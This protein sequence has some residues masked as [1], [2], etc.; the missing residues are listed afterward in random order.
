MSLPAEHRFIL[1]KL[2]R[3]LPPYLTY[4]TLEHTQDVLSCA[5]RIGLAENI[6]DHDMRL[7]LT[8]AA[9]HDSGYIFQSK[10]HEE[11][12]CEIARQ[13][14]AGFGYSGQEIETI[15]GMIRA[16]EVPQQ[17]ETF[18]EKIICDADL[19]YLG[20]DDFYALGLRLF[21]EMKHFGIVTDAAS[22]DNLQVRFLESHH[23]F[24]DISRQTRQPKK[25]QHLKELLAKIQ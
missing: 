13:D 14:L 10:G 24:T 12:S 7:L 11:K 8:A 18:L 2:Q 25:D 23:Y 6:S 20:R 15:C 1:E 9:Y 21:E 4:H 19:D 22:F 17:P 3:D 5:H 16:T